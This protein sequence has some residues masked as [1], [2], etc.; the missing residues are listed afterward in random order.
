MVQ[1]TCETCKKHS[2]KGGKDILNSNMKNSPDQNG[3]KQEV[4][5][6]VLGRRD[7]QQGCDIPGEDLT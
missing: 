4:D 3:S 5:F 1:N 6:L 2:S 7:N